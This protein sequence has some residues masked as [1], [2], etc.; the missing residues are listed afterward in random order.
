MFTASGLSSPILFISVEF[1]PHCVIQT[2]LMITRNFASDKSHFSAF[3]SPHLS[4][5]FPIID[6]TSSFTHF[7]QLA[8]GS[9]SQQAS[10]HLTAYSLLFF[11]SFLTLNPMV[12]ITQSCSS[13]HLHATV[14]RFIFLGQICPLNIRLNTFI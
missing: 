14:V 4:M 11:S 3:I 6:N 13:H 1:L 12:N 7:L 2:S 8:Y 10:S 9:S 5:A